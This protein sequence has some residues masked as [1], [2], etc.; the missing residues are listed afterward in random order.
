MAGQFREGLPLWILLR[1]RGNCFGKNVSEMYF[2]F[3][4]CR[5]QGINSSFEL[6]SFLMGRELRPKLACE[7]Q[8]VRMVKIIS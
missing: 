7:I 6:I 5:M 3:G 1:K 4:V 2:S 8:N